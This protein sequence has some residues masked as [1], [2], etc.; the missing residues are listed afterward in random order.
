[1]RGERQAIKT[2]QRECEDDKSNTNRKNN[3]SERKKNDNHSVHVLEKKGAAAV[4]ISEPLLAIV[5]LCQARR[6][7]REL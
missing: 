1:M 4:V 2:N 3:D 7:S 5:G 6:A